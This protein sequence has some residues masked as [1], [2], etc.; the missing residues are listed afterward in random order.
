MRIEIASANRLRY[1]PAALVALAFAL[2]TPGAEAAAQNRR[3]SQRPDSAHA[4]DSARSRSSTPASSP[5]P[6]P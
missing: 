5:N 3:P 4:G 2:M 1:L 6:R